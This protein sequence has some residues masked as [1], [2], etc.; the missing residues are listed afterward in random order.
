MFIALGNAL[1]AGSSLPQAIAHVA[2]ALP[3]P[4]SALLVRARDAYR[5]GRPWEDVLAGI[6]RDARWPAVEVAI[7]AMLIHRQTG[8]SLGALLLDAAEVMQDD[9]RLRRELQVATAQARLSAQIV[10]GLPVLIA[11]FLMVLS[12]DSMEPFYTSR[13]GSLLLV[14]AAVLDLVGFVL[15]VRASH[16]DF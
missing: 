10:G 1:Q 5:L 2:E 8:G 11:A 15:V 3:A 16:V 12:P 14:A 4:A 9:L 7:A 13:I 6:G